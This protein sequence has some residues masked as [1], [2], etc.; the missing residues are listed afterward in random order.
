MKEIIIHQAQNKDQIVNFDN[1]SE[2]INVVP[3]T[4]V[5]LKNEKILIVDDNKLNIKVA[6]R[7]LE[8]LN[9]SVDESES[10]FDCLSKIN[11]G[12]I[13]DLILMDI[14]MPEMDGTETF[15]KLKSIDNFSAPVIALTADAV[16]GAREKYLTIGFDEYLSKPFTKEQLQEEIELVFNNKKINSL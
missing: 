14:M 8:S 16:A 3:Q 10:G 15:K 11:G 5:V 13:Y 6:K 12:N 1:E 4:D 7:I 9:Y 2:N